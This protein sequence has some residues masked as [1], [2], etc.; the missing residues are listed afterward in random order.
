[1]PM[2]AVRRKTAEHLTAAWLNIPHVT[3]QEYADITGLEDLR[4]RYRK[5]V[6][7]AGGTS[8]SPRSPS[9]SSPRRC[10]TSRSSTPP[11]TWRRG[12]SSR[13]STCTSASLSIPTAACWC[14]S[15][16]TPTRRT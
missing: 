2:R 13:R 8:R 12:K 1:M 3:Q 9:R 16:A 14:L 15:S 10:V 4:R 11:S 6:E 7:A 5:T